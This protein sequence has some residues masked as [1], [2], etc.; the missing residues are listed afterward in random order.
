MKP[1]AGEDAGLVELELRQVDGRLGLLDP[2][3]RRLDLGRLR[4][5]LQPGELRLRTGQCSIGGGN[6][7]RGR[8]LQHLVVLRLCG[9]LRQGR[10]LELQ[11]LRHHRGVGVARDAVILALVD[12]DSRLRLLELGQDHALFLV[13]CALQC[14]VVSGAGRADRS[15][16]CRHVGRLRLGLRQLHLG[17]GQLQRGLRLRAAPPPPCCR[18][19]RAGR[20]ASRCRPPRRLPPG[21]APRPRPRRARWPRP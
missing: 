14:P 9:L 13:G 19:A 7:V 3:L 20:P 17:L 21:P 18:C 15:L 12:R 1:S 8:A 10:L 11:R 6:L 4:A 5:P 2:G 16:R